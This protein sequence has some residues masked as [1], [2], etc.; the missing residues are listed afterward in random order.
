MCNHHFHA[1]GIGYQNMIRE[2]ST[3]LHVRHIREHYH[4]SRQ[5][6]V[7]EVGCNR[8][9]LLEEIR[10]LC[11]SAYGID[12]DEAVVAH[13]SQSGNTVL[14]CDADDLAFPDRA[15]DAVVSIHTIE[16]VRDLSRT[17]REFARVLKP[18]GTLVL[19]YPYEPIVGI[20]C[21][22]FWA[23][24]NRGNVHLRAVKP[25]A[26]SDIVRKN[27]LGLIP[28]HSGMYFV[29]TPNFISVFKK[30]PG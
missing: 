3:R 25:R 4:A 20:T 10:R 23:L 13:A 30:Q 19:I 8:G 15:F 14:V 1:R 12:I 28:V 18:G 17:M 27:G 9:F 22:P 29:L 24:S 6:S 26:L 7:L 2:W 11:R 5:H 21:I 16:H